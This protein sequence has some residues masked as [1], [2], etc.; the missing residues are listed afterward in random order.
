MKIS[1]AGG[2]IAGLELFMAFL[3]PAPDGSLTPGTRRFNWLWYRNELDASELA[4]HL[5]DST[6][7]VHYASVGPGQL[8]ATSLAELRSLAQVHLPAGLS[9]LVL[10][11][12]TP[13]V[14]AIF[15]ALSPGFVEGRVPLIGDAACTLRPHTGSGTSKAADDAVSLADALASSNGGVVR[16][17]V[18]WAMARR[19]AIQP[20]LQKRPQLA[21]G[22]GL[23][24]AL[25]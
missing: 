12:S 21:A 15:D 5:T 7:R 2:S 19:V 3:I 24:N 6:G 13:F 1:I 17:L 14:Q 16:Q 9:Q 18:D 4:R 10:A 23:G 25:S 8:A 20:L 22:S 11:T